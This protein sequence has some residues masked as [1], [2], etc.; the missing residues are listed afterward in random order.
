MGPVLQQNRSEWRT[1]LQ[2]IV[3]V[4][5]VVL[6]DAD[7]VVTVDVVAAVVVDADVVVVEERK[8]RN[9]FLSPSLVVWSRI[10]RSSLWRR[11]TSSLCPS[12]SLKSLTSSWAPSEG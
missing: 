1:Q 12:K 11:S 4:S 10:R 3:V 2:P 7:V 5:V 6:V 9:G 8:T